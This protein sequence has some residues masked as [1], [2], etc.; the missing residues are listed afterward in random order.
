MS[1]VFGPFF[2]LFGVDSY[3]KTLHFLSA[4]YLSSHSTNDF[5]A[6]S[7]NLDSSKEFIESLQSKVDVIKLKRIE[8]LILE[9]QFD[10]AIK[11]I[12]SLINSCESNIETKFQSLLFSENAVLKKE[13]QRG[14]VD[15]DIILSISRDHISKMM[16]LAQNGPEHLYL[17]TQIAS[18]ILDINELARHEYNLY[19]NH[20]LNKEGDDL[21]WQFSLIQERKSIIKRI[22]DSYNRF[23]ELINVVIDKNYFH[24][25]PILI[26]RLQSALAYYITRLRMEGIE[27]A[28]NYFISEIKFFYKFSMGIIDIFDNEQYE[29]LCLPMILILDTDTAEQIKESITFIESEILKI[30]NK[31]VSARVQKH[32]IDSV[33]DFI[34]S[35]NN[36]TKELSFEQEIDV[37]KEMAKSL[38]IDLSDEDNEIT[39]IVNIGIKDI[40]PERVLKNCIHLFVRLGSCG[41]P[42]QYLKLPTAGSKILICIKHNYGIESLDLDRLYESFKKFHCN[43]CKDNEPHLQD[44]K[45]NRKWQIEQ[46]EKYQK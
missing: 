27:E 22:H 7:K 19:I 9:L 4:R 3:I 26:I 33:N 5:I 13:L 24:I 36:V 23:R 6:I 42:G 46:N 10:E 29:L 31:E 15:Q 17:Y 43:K 8:N 16:E 2:R 18:I 44:W 39:K 45:W 35:K 32:F 38:G 20:S 21:L 1:I 14:N 41:L 34:E 40:N 12:K 37:Y 25:I 28:K 11:H 30:S